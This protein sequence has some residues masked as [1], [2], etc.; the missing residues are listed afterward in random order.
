MDPRTLLRIEGAAIL[1]FALGGY[2]ILE[3]PFWLLIVLALAPDISM[4]GYLGGAR[5]GAWSYN[6]FHT[7]ALPL[8]LGAIGFWGQYRLALLVALVWVGHIGADR[9]LGYGLKFESG[10]NRTHLSAEQ[11]PITPREQSD[12]DPIA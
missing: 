3:G 10:F 6:L 4:V 8:A 5:I 9:L 1:G 7:Y 11:T 12:G 2:F